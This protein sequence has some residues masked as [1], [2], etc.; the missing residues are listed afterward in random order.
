MPYFSL[1]SVFMTFLKCCCNVP[2]ATWCHLVYSYFCTTAVIWFV[3][4]VL[5]R[6]AFVCDSVLKRNFCYSKIAFVFLDIWWVMN[7]SGF[8]FVPWI[9][10]SC[11]AIIIQHPN[12]WCCSERSFRNSGVSRTNLSKNLLKEKRYK[13]HHREVNDKNVKCCSCFLGNWLWMY[14]W[15]HR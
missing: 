7:V 3:N 9:T 2:T 12:I 11:A 1:E 8:Q 14:T 10:M 5:H 4:E 15:K 13:R 6:D